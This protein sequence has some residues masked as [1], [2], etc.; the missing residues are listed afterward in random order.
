MSEKLNPCPI[1]GGEAEI[2]HI[3]ARPLVR[4]KNGKVR[5]TFF[6][7]KFYIIRCKKCLAESNLPDYDLHKAM[8][9]WNHAIPERQCH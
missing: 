4:T 6:R 1:C 9:A 8:D 7:K 3:K 2:T 5:Y